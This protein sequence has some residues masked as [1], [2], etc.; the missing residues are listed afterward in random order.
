MIEMNVINHTKK[1][2]NMKTNINIQ[3]ETELKTS[4][5]ISGILTKKIQSKD[6]HSSK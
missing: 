2:R 4:I 3:F 5:E 1:K 6:V